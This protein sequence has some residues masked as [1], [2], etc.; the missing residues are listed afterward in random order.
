[1]VV[2]KNG[3]KLTASTTDG[4]PSIRRE[5]AGVTVER[6]TLAQLADALTQV[7]QIPVFDATGL[8][9]RYDATVDVTPYIPL[10]NAATGPT[11]IVSIAITALQDLLGLRLEA[12]KTQLEVLV[13][14]HAER[15]P[16]AD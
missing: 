10:D 12:R 7:M 1:L 8:T 3:P 13:V 15:T 11:D 4:P 5:R 14:D 16:A 2:A 6:A 9:G